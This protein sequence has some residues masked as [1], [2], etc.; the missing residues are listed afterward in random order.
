MQAILQFLTL[1]RHSSY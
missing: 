1:P